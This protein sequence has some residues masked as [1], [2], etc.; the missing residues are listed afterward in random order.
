MRAPGMPC[1]ECGARIVADPL[2]LLTELKLTCTSCGLVL[3]VDLQQSAS[4]I[5]ALRDNLED[6]K[7]IKGD[8]QEAVGELSGKAPRDTRRRKR[9]VRMRGKNNR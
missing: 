2:A 3:S 7:R 5:N 1:P 8:Y 9:A 6:F 4:T